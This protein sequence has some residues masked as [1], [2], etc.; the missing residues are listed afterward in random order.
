MRIPASLLWLM[1]TQVPSTLIIWTRAATYFIPRLALYAQAAF[2]TLSTT[3]VIGSGSHPRLRIGARTPRDGYM[4][5]SKHTAILYALRGVIE[6]LAFLGLA[7]ED[8]QGQPD[9][10]A[11]VENWHFNTTRRIREIMEEE[12]HGSRIRRG[13]ERDPCDYDGTTSCMAM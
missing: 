2:F 6:D 3:A 11:R 7:L 1:A 12:T 13:P 5:E 9:I 10:E 8:W 4:I